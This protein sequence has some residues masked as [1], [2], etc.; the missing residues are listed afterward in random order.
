MIHLTLE[1]SSGQPKLNDVIT[2][3]VIVFMFLSFS[4]QIIKFGV[5]GDT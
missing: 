5:T 4:D 1:T 2:A 3:I